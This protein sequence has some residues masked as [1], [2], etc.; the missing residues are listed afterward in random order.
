MGEERRHVVVVADFNFH[1]TL[2]CCY[3]KQTDRI[4]HTQQTDK[5]SSIQKDKNIRNN[6]NSNAK[7]FKKVTPTMPVKSSPSYNDKQ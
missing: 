2:H 6:T 3:N 7:T 4:L 1:L 5:K